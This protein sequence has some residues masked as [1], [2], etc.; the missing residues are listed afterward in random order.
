MWT[1]VDIGYKDFEETRRWF[2]RLIIVV[3]IYGFFNL[4]E[5]VGF[6]LVGVVVGVSR[7]LVYF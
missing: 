4:G 5:F 6:T 3:R 7:A 2:S 1:Y